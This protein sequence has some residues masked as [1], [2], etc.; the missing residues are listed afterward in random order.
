MKSR[1]IL[2]ICCLFVMSLLLVIACNNQNQP[3]PTSQLND[4]PIVIGYST[5]AGWWP[6]AIAEEEGLFAANKVNVQL[7]WFDGYLE[8]LQALAAGQLDGNCQTLND[9][10]AFAGD[11]VNGEVVVL[12]N[13]NSAGNDKIIVSEEINTIED[14]KGKKVAV[15]EGVV[16]DF[17]LALALEKQGMSREDVEIVNLET[18]QAVLAFVTEKVDAVGAFAPFWLTA[19]ERPG[20]KE[21]ISSKD[22]PGAIADLLVL[23]QKLIDEQ[24]EQV[25]AI[26]KTWF[27]IREFMEKNPE[28]ADEIMA[29]RAN[30][31]VKDLKKF[32]EGVKFFTLEDNL[33]AFTPGN[34]ME[35]MPYAAE[36]IADF[37]LK[38][39]FLTKIPDLNQIF[40]ARFVKVLAAKQS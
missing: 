18:G 27:D 14:L 29:K 10:I 12:V 21:L 26:V 25:Q 4:K 22:F 11:A 7:K 39:G 3:S 32:E 19:L 33:K 30:I 1:K 31:T 37:L 36:K 8:S 23:S 5:W 34:N 6:W 2:T 16:D 15:E 40:D 17:L 13:D 24:P 38:F 20:S 28:R 9:T 35:H